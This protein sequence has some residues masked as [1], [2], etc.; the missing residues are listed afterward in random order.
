MSVLLDKNSKILVQGA[1]GS[2]GSTHLRLMVEYDR[3]NN[4]QSLLAGV[5][6][7]KGG[8]Q[9]EGIPIFDTVLEAKDKTGVNTSVI[10]VPALFAKDATF[11][12]IDAGLELIVV[13]TE[14]IPVRDEIEIQRRAKYTKSKIIGPN[15]PGV[16]TPGKALAGIHPESV[17]KPGKVGMVSRSGTLTYEIAL[18]LT[19]EGVGQSTCIGIG[20]DPVPGLGFIES[21]ELFEKDPETEVIC[22]MGEIGGNAEE[23]VA[24]YIKEN[25]SKPVI[26]YVAGATAPEGKTMGHAGAIVS[27]GSSSGSYGAKKEALEKS[28]IL[29]ARTPWELVNLAKSKTMVNC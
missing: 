1:T 23:K 8:R 26:A 29:F 22:M 7:G 14:G 11:E 18:G 27:E 13:I 17:Y 28:G 2:M 19:N 16:I 6:P 24:E 9:I 4:R 12:A 25:C 3:K 15:C 21:I 10:F 20:G 5:T